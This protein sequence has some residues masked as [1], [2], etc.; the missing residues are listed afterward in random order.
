MEWGWAPRT[1]N[2]H[3]FVTC[4]ALTPSLSLTF[5]CSS[6]VW[7]NPTSTFL[8]SQVVNGL[9]K[10]GKWWP[11]LLIG[12]CS[13]TW[14]SILSLTSSLQIIAVS[15]TWSFKPRLE[16]SEW[17]SSGT[18]R[19]GVSTSASR[20][21]RPWKASGHKNQIMTKTPPGS[22]AVEEILERCWATGP[23]VLQL[24]G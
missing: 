20:R 15:I 2:V 17:P 23:D 10:N 19:R 3:S 21:R 14:Q 13:Q 16:W 8:K 6:Y 22:Q 9:L 1:E 7:H 5:N 12:N 18:R 11:Y 24:L 4:L